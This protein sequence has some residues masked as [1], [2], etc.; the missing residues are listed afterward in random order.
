MTAHR[1]AGSPTWRTNCDPRLRI[2]NGG[3]TPP[4]R[5]GADRQTSSVSHD[6][7]TGSVQ[8]R[9]PAAHGRLQQVSQ[10]RAKGNEL[11][12]VFRIS[13][14]MLLPLRLKLA[15]DEVLGRFKNLLKYASKCCEYAQRSSAAAASP[16]GYSTTTELPC[17]SG[18]RRLAA[19][20]WPS[21][22]KRT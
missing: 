19:S 17:S 12:R 18:A 4:R 14:R 20:V 1:P 6:A 21:A 22:E 11:Y 10:P 8:N 5:R 9:A 16:S 3:K 7:T 13:R 15:A 2:A